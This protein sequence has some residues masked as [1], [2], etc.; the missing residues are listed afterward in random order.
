MR[1]PVQGIGSHWD[2]WFR[3][4]ASASDSE[5][6]EAIGNSRFEQSR[7]VTWLARRWASEAQWRGEP[8]PIRYALAQLSRVSPF[9]KWPAFDRYRTTYG[10]P[11]ISAIVIDEASTGEPN[12]VRR[13]EALTLPADEDA[14]AQDV[15]TE[16][17]QAES[18][19]LSAARQAALSLLDGRGLVAFLA[20]WIATGRRPYPLWLRVGLLV[21]WLTVA[22]LIVRLLTGSDPGDRLTLFVG[23]LVG[24]W[25]VLVLTALT[26][27][28]TLSIRAWLA[29]R[30]WHRRLEAYQ[31]RL[32]INGGLSLQGGSAGLAFCLNILLAT[33][34]SHPH[35]PT[36]S[37]LWERFFQ[38]LRLGANNW[39]ATGA[40]SPQGRVE[41]VAIEPKIRACLQHPEITD[42]L[43]P[44]QPE[45]RQSV[46]NR[47]ML[48]S[49]RTTRERPV[50]AGMTLVFA[51]ERKRLLSHRC[52]Y[53]AQS[54]LAVGDFASKSQLAANVLALGVSTVMLIAIPDIRNVLDPPPPP[55]VVA[56]SS[57]SPYYLWVS[58]DTKRPEAFD[59]VFESGFCSN[60]R[61]DVAQY[62]DPGG[63]ARAEIRLS[64]LS[65]QTNID[66]EDGT[67]RIER[68]RK[69][70]A[71]D[72]Q[73]G[74]QVGSYSFSYVSRLGNE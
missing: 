13:V 56:P 30:Q 67:V 34:R 66:Q 37:W 28:G 4:E 35:L 41:S 31:T 27:A 38:N 40:V 18:A 1:S 73:S 9:D 55:A 16:G 74:E 26:I 32:R 71:R 60:R 36:R 59:V 17:F 25:S 51:S 46:I 48:T 45:A 43:T 58:L 63:S 19:D 6:I 21:A 50:S 69:F 44:W 72:Y 2:E 29:G 57:P 52:H 42:V 62:P 33:F 49:V 8:S 70:L 24:L 65:R 20:L 53:A 54:I 39:A 22:G 68:R 3:H 23:L 12:D 61:A 64:R 5:A 15:V 14:A 7:F 11:G 47:L 10:A